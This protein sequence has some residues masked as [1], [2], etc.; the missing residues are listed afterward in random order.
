L[1]FINHYCLGA[2]VAI[3]IFDTTK[4]SSFEKAEKLLQ[5][6]EPLD[7][8]FKILVG[9]KIDLLN[10]KKNN[11][12]PVLQKDAEI[13]AK[14]YNAEYFPCNST[15]DV[16]VNPIFGALMDSI[17]TFIGKNMELQNLIGKNISVGKRIFTHPVFFNN[18]KENCLFKN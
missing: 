7:I 8:P 17:I 16:A 15:Q 10:I 12:N 13:L 11:P 5:T 2:A 14:N 1:K 18:L 6:I 3:I 9:N 4:Y